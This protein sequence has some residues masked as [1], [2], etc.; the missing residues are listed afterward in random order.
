[1]LSSE[2]QQP[3]DLHGAFRAHHAGLGGLA[4]E[5]D[6]KKGRDGHGNPYPPAQS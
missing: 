5:M 1:M 4:V 3:S 6:M 2:V